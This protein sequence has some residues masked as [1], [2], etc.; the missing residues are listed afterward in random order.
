MAAAAFIALAGT[1]CDGPVFVGQGRNGGQ[2][3]NG[4]TSA[5]DRPVGWWIGTWQA[6]DGSRLY[7]WENDWHGTGDVSGSGR[8]YISGGMELV[9]HNDWGRIV[10][11]GFLNDHAILAHIS[12][13][14][15]LTF[16]RQSWGPP[17]HWV[18]R[19]S[20]IFE[21]SRRLD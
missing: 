16:H 6:N 7:L 10:T 12:G 17:N 2:G 18:R 21:T 1:S 9:F 5:P 15:A 20:T 8:F 11:V 13:W 14:G 4:A 3:E 19:N